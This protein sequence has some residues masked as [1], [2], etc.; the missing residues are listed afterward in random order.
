MGTYYAGFNLSSNSVFVKDS[1]IR[2]AFNLAVNKK[3]IIDE[4]LGG[5]GEEA[6]GPM[7]PNMVDNGYLSGF[8]Y[9]PRL[10][11]EI[12]NKKRALIGNT[13]L[14]ILIRDESSETTFSK[15]AQFIIND[16][17]EVGIECIVDKVS[18]D[19]YHNPEIIKRSDLFLSRWISDTGD[20]DNFL[21]PMFNPANL[22]DFTGYNN[23]EVTEMMSKAKGI[24][25]PQKRIQMY[26]DIQK[27]IVEDTPWIFLYHPQLGY[28]SREGVIGV[29][30]SPLGIVRYEDIIIEKE[31]E[32]NL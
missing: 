5:L 24:I 32:T 7:P 28:V 2:N 23:S 27:I 17:K 11:R 26:K 4:I 1:E 3:K 16:L 30:V 14:K 22:T 31:T 15:I 9:N 10:A 19:K 8:G 25:N 13:K 18:P 21:Q 6:K 29:R 12:L 20:M